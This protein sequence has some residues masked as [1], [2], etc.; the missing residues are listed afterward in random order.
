MRKKRGAYHHGN[1][2][3]ALIEAA[4]ALVARDGVAR[5]SLRDVARRL[6]VSHQAPYNHFP[7]KGALLDAIASEGFAQLADQL[8]ATTAQH[9]EP[10]ARVIE[11][12][13]TYVAFARKHTAHYRVMFAEPDSERGAPPPD[14]I[15]QTAFHVL[16]DAILRGQE[17]G[18]FSTAPARELALAC[19]AF[20]HGL[21]MLAIDGKLGAPSDALIRTLLQHEVLGM[22]ADTRAAPT[23]VRAPAASKPSAAAGGDAR[24]ASRAGAARSGSRSRPSLRTRPRRRS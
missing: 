8:R 15:G 9:A 17:D 20:V 10:V 3:A 13:F 24:P 14:D 22:V 19:F 18:T 21:A 2:R 1:L 5:L 6:G 23:V 16:V 7:D 4:L 11:S 12:G